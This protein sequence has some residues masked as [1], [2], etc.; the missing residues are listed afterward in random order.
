MNRVGAAEDGAGIS[1][2]SP[3]VGL[4][5]FLPTIIDREMGILASV[6]VALPLDPNETVALG[7][8]RQVDFPT[9]GFRL[10]RNPPL[11]RREVDQRFGHC[12]QFVLRKCADRTHDRRNMPFFGC[13]N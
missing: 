1:A 9:D 13:E 12:C 3:A 2:V 8:Y 6:K 10:N 4:F 11:E 5:I 7:D